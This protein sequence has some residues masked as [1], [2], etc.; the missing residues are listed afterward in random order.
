VGSR[1]RVRLRGIHSRGVWASPV[2]GGEVK[3]R[4]WGGGAACGRSEG[5]A[6]RPAWPRCIGSCRRG[7]TALWL[8]ACPLACPAVVQNGGTT[9]VVAW[10]RTGQGEHDGKGTTGV[11][12]L[13]CLLTGWARGRRR[14][15]VASQSRGDAGLCCATWDRRCSYSERRPG[16]APRGGVAS[17]FEQRPPP[18]S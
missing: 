15:A 8:K 6:L 12:R 4:L 9:P 1:G 7:R 11:R 13:G 2:C 5:R 17:R 16:G 18:P 3:A 14:N 10:Q